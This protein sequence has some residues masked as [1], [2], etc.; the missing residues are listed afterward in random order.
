MVPADN[1]VYGKMEAMETRIKKKSFRLNKQNKS[2]FASHFLVHSFATAGQLTTGNSNV[3]VYPIIF[4][5]FMILS[6]GF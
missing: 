4:L 3:K 2:T 6:N 5:A 1:R